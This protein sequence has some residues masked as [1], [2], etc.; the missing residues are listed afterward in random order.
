MMM[1]WLGGGGGGGCVGGCVGAAGASAALLRRARRLAASSSG[2][3]TGWSM[4]GGARWTI[5][6]DDIII[7]T[8]NSSE[9]ER[10]LSFVHDMNLAV[11]SY[12]LNDKFS[13]YYQLKYLHTDVPI[14]PC[15]PKTRTFIF[16]I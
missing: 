10:S 8:S 7:S 9:A 14:V 4:A 5:F 12:Q 16:L 2:S 1:G 15:D 6:N 13:T 3:S 11:L